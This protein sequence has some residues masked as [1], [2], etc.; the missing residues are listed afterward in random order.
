MDVGAV[1]VASFFLQTVWHAGDASLSPSPPT[2]FVDEQRLKATAAV[3]NEERGCQPLGNGGNRRI[4][5]RLG[6]AAENLLQQPSLVTSEDM[7][8]I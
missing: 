6:A 2:S 4:L 1:Q 8:P 3:G 5:R 7:T